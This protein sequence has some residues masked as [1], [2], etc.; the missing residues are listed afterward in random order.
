MNGA[1]SLVDRRLVHLK[2]SGV[3]PVAAIMAIHAEFG[4]SLAEA[5][6]AISLSSAWAREAANGDQLHREMLAALANESKT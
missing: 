5:K 4:L 2:A 1:N 3:A 6:L